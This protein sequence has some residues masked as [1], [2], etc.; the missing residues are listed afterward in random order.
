MSKHLFL[1]SLFAFLLL[2][3][4]GQET[5]KHALIVV[6][7]ETPV[8]PEFKQKIYSYH[9]LNGH[10]TGREE[11]LVVNGKQGGK[12]YIRTDLGTCTLYKDRYMITGIGNIIDLKEKKVLFDG[13]AQLVRCSNDSA[14]FY[15][16]DFAKGKFYSVYNFKTNTYGEVK[17]LTFKA[18]LGQ[19]VE[20]DKTA[21]PYKLNLYPQNKPKVELTKDAGYGQKTADGKPI[22]PPMW[23]IDNSTFIY[24]YYNKEN[25]EVAFYKFNAD[26]KASTLMGKAPFKPGLKAPVL[27]KEDKNVTTLNYG[28]KIIAVNAKNDKVEDLSFTY[29]VNGFAAEVKES[30][31]GRR[32][33]QANNNKELGKY[34]FQLK[35]FKTNDKTIALVK[36]LIIGTDSYQQGMAVWNYDQM[37]FEKVD[38]DEVLTLVGWINEY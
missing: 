10:F 18:K 7:V 21:A 25:T 16:N 6:H 27:A 13:R 33:L 1:F 14:I 5:N 8:K 19:D 35:N 28:D 37:K 17:N 36:E 2:G 30:N 20:F 34:H 23:W 22:D 29:P 11:L 38:A 32:I 4:H 31:P 26:T 24:A 12:D 9:F 15:T 3:L